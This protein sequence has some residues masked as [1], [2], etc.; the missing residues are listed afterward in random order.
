MDKWIGLP[1]VQAVLLANL[2]G[3]ESGDALADVLF[4]D[5]NPSGR[6]PYTIGRS[7][8][9]YGEGAKVMYL[10]NGV[11]PQQDFKEGLYIDYRHFDKHDIAPRFEFGFGLSYDL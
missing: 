6:L 1:N 4:G 5:V 10:P 3:Q 7:A 11:V 2:P 9:Q 8:E